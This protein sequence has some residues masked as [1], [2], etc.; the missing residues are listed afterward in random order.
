MSSLAR[1]GA[2][3]ITLIA[4]LG[5]PDGPRGP[6]F[7]VVPEHY[8]ELLT[9]WEKVYDEMPEDAVDGRGWRQRLVVWKRL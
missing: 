7:Y 8:D 5:L 3:L 6:P 9:E 1:P 2:F 4:P